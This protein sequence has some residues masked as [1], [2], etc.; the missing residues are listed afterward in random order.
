MDRTNMKFGIV[1]TMLLAVCLSGFA[2]M[3]VAWKKNF[4]GGYHDEFYSV[5]AV[6][7]G[8]VMVGFVPLSSFG[9]DDTD[10]LTARGNWDAMIVKYSLDGSVVWKQNFGGSAND[11][12]NAVVAV[13]DGIVAVGYSEAGSFGNGDWAGFT[14]KGKWDAIIVK[15]N[16]DGSIAWKK[17]FGGSD[18][19]EFKSVTVVADGIIAAGDV[20]RESFGN[21]DLAGLTPKGLLSDAIL[22]KY[23]FDGSIAWIKNFSLGGGDSFEAV[24]TVSD[25]IVAVG[26]SFSANNLFDASIV[27]FNFDGS[28]AWSQLFVGRQSEFYYSVT[29]T[30]DGI[31]AAGV[32]QPNPGEGLADLPDLPG[33]G[34]YDAIIVKYNFDGSMAWKKNFGGSDADCFNS[35]T[36]VSD[37]ILAAGY[38]MVGSFGNGDWTGVTGKGGQD[39]ILVQYNFDGSMAWK[40]NFGGD[41]TDCFQS[42]ITVSDGMVAAGYAIINGSGDWAGLKGNGY[43]DGVI[44]KFGSGTNHIADIAKTQNIV[45]YPNPTNNLLYVTNYNLHEDTVIEIYDIVGKKM[46]A[47]IRKAV[48]EITLD[49]SYL[50]SGIYFLRI[51]DDIVKVVK[52]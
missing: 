17:N 38:S 44:V 14:A 43:L 9:N 25:G 36:A 40:K 31:V 19:D 21:G 18:N 11:L 15:Y 46:R 26:S 37:G 52:K 12:Y 7:D 2:Q 33:K 47:E 5:A 28:V 32:V 16:F 34:S 1:L 45:V 13:P 10:G 23:N 4:G 41:D 35:I 20:P 39:A 48:E 30:S 51:N 8:Y 29:A 6:P 24:T 50:P 3:D 49:I 27:K 22:V 42:I